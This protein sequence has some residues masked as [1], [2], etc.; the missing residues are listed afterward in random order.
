MGFSWQ[1]VFEPRMRTEMQGELIG[2][3]GLSGN[4]CSYN[5][6]ASNKC[7]KEIKAVRHE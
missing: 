7:L 1:V 5:R 6:L 3:K 4:A 2:Q